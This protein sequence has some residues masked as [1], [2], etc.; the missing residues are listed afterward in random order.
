[1]LK[2]TIIVKVH[3]LVSINTNCSLKLRKNSGFCVNITVIT[4]RMLISVPAVKP[5]PPTTVICFIPNSNVL[6]LF[7]SLCFWLQYHSY[8]SSVLVFCPA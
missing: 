7:S 5:A 6:S 3:N 4:Q 2:V 8:N 1:M